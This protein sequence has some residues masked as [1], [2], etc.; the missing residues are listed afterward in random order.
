MV[1]NMVVTAIPFIK[2]SQKDSKDE[3]KSEAK[4]F[5]SAWLNK[6]ILILKK[7]INLHYFYSFFFYGFFKNVKLNLETG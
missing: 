3:K 2:L 5:S 4:Q 7:L 1:I 6:K